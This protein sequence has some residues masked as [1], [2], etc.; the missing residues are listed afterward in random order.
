MG[1]EFTSSGINRELPVNLDALFLPFVDERH[2]FLFK[3]RNG[4]DTPLKAKTR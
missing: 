2:G 4:R 3:V 1:V